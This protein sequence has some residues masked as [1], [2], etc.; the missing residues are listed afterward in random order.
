ML[1]CMAP[2]IP[3]TEPASFTAGDSITWRIA[4]SDYPATD[5]WALSYTLTNSAGAFSITSTA[6]GDAHLVSVAASASA[7]WSA[8][9]YSMVGAVTKGTERITLRR[10]SVRVL[11]LFDGSAAA[12]TRSHARKMLDAIEA[13]LETRDPAVASYTIHGRAMQYID[14]AD[15]LKLRN[16]YRA[17]V[18]AE[19]RAAAGLSFNKILVRL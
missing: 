2:T 11:P 13:W 12:D 7:L 19:E 3:T 18:R 8:G 14:I 16:Q 15:L 9:V 6:D 1:P 4:L 5:G 10:A 17:E